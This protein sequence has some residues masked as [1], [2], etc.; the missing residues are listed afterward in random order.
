[1]SDNTSKFN[2]VVERMVAIRD[3]RSELKK[4]FEEADRELRELF[5]RGEAWLLNHLTET[6]AT[7]MKCPS[8]TAFVKEDLRVSLGDW[9]ALAQYVIESGDV[10][11]LEHRVSKTAVKTFM[12]QNNGELPPGVT[13]RTERVVQVRRA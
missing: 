3:Q 5:A 8:G 13:T 1:M 9:D 7:S 4:Q 6:G 11:M 2:S 10:E 12:E